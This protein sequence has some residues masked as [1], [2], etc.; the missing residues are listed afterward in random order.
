MNRRT[1]LLTSATAAAAAST[2]PVRSEAQRESQSKPLPPA[3]ATLTNR[4]AE[5]TPISLEEREHRIDRARILMRLANIDAL[6][7]CTGTSLTYFTGL[8]WGISERFFAWV[9]PAK[10]NPFVVCP[11]FEEGRVRERMESKPV[12]LPQAANTRVYP[13]NEDENPYR[14]LHTALSD[15][16]VATGS[17]AMEERTPFMFSDGIAQAS[18]VLSIVSANPV[19]HGCRGVKSPAELALLQLANTVTLSVYKAFYQSVQ[20]GMTN[21]QAV[22]FIDAAYRRCGFPGEAS[23]QVDQYSALP[24]GSLQPQVIRE[25]SIVLID[26]GCSVQGYTS[27]ITRTLIIGKAPAGQLDEQRKV[28]DVVKQAQAAALARARPGVPCEAIDKAARDIVTAAGFGPGFRTFSHR[29]GHGI[30]MDMHE[31]PYLVGGNTQPLV[32]GMCFS[33]EP[34]IYQVGKLGVRLEDCW[35]V[36]EDGGKM[37]TPTSPSLDHPFGDA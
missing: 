10:G 11:A 27:D 36:T 21:V 37:F 23:C 17:I 29:V 2:L 28:F 4:S 9:L 12:T 13:W 3:I 5:A 15:V 1:F 16:G 18:P 24:H 34:G 7:I 8:R 35:H 14:I 6:V 22:D 33:D 31:W 26:D 30:G 32:P 19:I 25:G 20:P